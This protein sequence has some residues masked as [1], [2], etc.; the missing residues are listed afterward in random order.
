MVCNMLYNLMV[1]L[2]NNITDCMVPKWESIPFS[3]PT[4]PRL[5]NQIIEHLVLVFPWPKTLHKTFSINSVLDFFYLY[6]FTLNKFVL[7][8]RSSEQFSS[9]N[10]S[11]LCWYASRLETSHLNIFVLSFYNVDQ[12]SQVYS[13]AVEEMI[14]RPRSSRSANDVFEKRV[15]K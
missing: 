5:S 1:I 10:A 6:F 4:K 12:V 8:V 9:G 15:M 7:F 11:S 13:G 2:W 3:F 14:V